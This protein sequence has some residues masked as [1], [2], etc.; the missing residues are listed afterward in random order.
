MIPSGSSMFQSVPPER[1]NPHETPRRE[2]QPSLLFSELLDQNHD[3]WRVF[4]NGNGWVFCREI[5]DTTRGLPS[6]MVVLAVENNKA[7]AIHLYTNKGRRSLITTYGDELP[8]AIQLL[9]DRERIIGIFTKLAHTLAPSSWDHNL[10]FSK[11]DVTERHVALRSSEAAYE[12]LVGDIKGRMPVTSGSAFKT[13]MP[14]YSRGISVSEF[15][16]GVPF[17]EYSITYP[18]PLTGR[19]FSNRLRDGLNATTQQ[20]VSLVLEHNRTVEGRV[21]DSSREEW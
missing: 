5:G 7:P 8:A 6:G 16:G 13:I 20:M 10:S 19:F 14:A 9:V 15:D 1:R 4:R 17:V 21:A 12:H 18:R 11:L 3:A 2:R